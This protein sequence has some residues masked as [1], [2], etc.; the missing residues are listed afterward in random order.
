[1]SQTAVIKRINPK[2]VLKKISKLK[3]KNRILKIPIFKNTIEKIGGKK[4][5]MKKAVRERYSKAGIAD[6]AYSYPISDTF[7]LSLH[8]LEKY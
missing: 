6:T 4:F 7:K 3:F 5:I 2:I 1:M 8:F